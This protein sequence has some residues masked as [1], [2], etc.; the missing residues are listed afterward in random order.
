MLLNKQQVKSC[1]L[2]HAFLTTLNK[3]APFLIE[4][5]YF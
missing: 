3:K 4:K 2:Q 1:R 5:K